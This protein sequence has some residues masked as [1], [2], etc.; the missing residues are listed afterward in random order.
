MNQ[1][2]LWKNVDLLI[3]RKKK[4]RNDLLLIRG[5]LEEIMA[6]QPLFI[7]YTKSQIDKMLNDLNSQFL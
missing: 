6:D 2:D 7:S 5:N 1:S 4:L 3:R